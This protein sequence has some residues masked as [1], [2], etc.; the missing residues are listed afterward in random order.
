M[1]SAATKFRNFVSVHNIG[2]TYE[3]RD[4]LVL[5][6][7]FHYVFFRIS[8]ARSKTSFFSQTL[9]FLKLKVEC[10]EFI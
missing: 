10:K 4:L 5:K 2:S 6:V 1:Y 8:G 7:R 9:A 3:N